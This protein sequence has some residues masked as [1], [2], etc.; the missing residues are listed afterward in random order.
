MILCE[1]LVGIG[2]SDGPAIILNGGEGGYIGDDLELARVNL[3]TKVGRADLILELCD[4]E[5][6]K[7]TP[8]E[9]ILLAGVPETVKEHLT[10]GRVVDVI[11]GSRMLGIANPQIGREKEDGVID[12]AQ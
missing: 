12:Y 2:G 4:S 1:Y 6:A 10:N 7:K 11:D 8:V 9:F 3:I 5:D